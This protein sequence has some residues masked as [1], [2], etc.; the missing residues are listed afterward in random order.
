MSKRE[1]IM[2]YNVI[3]NCVKK[4]GAT[5]KEIYAQL[6]RAFELEGYDFGYTQRTF[7]RDLNDIRAIFK[8]DIRYDFSKKRFLLQ[9]DGGEELKDRMLEAYET[10]NALKLSDGFSEYIDF[11][12]RRASGLE[13]FHGLLHAIKN[14]LQLN[15]TYQSYQDDEPA[16]RKTNP[17][18]LKEFKNRW[19]VVANDL[20]TGIIKTYALDRI[21][22]IEITK[23]R[24]TLPDNFDPKGL[25]DHSYGI[26]A[27]VDGAIPEKVVLS[28]TPD[29]G[30][31]IKSLP[32]H[33]SQEI[34]IDD[35]KELRIQLKVYIVFDFLKELLSYGKSLKVVEPQSLVN[36]L[37]KIDRI[38]F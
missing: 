9:Q 22:S 6:Q 17:Y 21:C 26:I 36:K 32:L 15:I 12:K 13:N 16:E 19:Y 14:R 5:F 3:V 2:R 20:Q 10:Y 38:S 30:R 28:F 35:E 18:L 37:S 29:Q 33:H 23:K 24:F 8:H 27:S 31:Y 4:S 1:S 7:Q 34:L 11:E 25:F